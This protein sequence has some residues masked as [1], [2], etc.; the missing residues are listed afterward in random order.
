MT[1]SS[2]Y[3]NNARLFAVR[4]YLM[5]DQSG[6]LVNTVFPMST[7]TN[8]LQPNDVILALDGMKLANDGTVHFRASML[9]YHEISLFFFL[10]CLLLT[11]DQ[12]ILCIMYCGSDLTLLQG[13]AFRLI[14]LWT[15][16][17]VV[18]EQHLT[19]GEMAR[20]VLQYWYSSLQRQ[21]LTCY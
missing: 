14:T 15:W 5:L 2:G 4:L 7:C 11:N 21:L 18:T 16:N 19:F 8:V 6:I 3:C 1:N 13:S 10:L 17:S 12:V 20:F 9:W